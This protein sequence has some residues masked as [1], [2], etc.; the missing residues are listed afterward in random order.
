MPTDKRTKY[1]TKII[2][3]LT[4]KYLEICSMFKL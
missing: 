4:N 1:K 3:K 2:N